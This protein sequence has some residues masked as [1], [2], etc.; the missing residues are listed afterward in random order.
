MISY[1]EPIR[2]THTIGTK[3]DYEF[4][5]VASLI[6]KQ[7]STDEN[8][9]PKYKDG[10]AATSKF[11]TGVLME[12]D[13]SKGELPLLTLRPTA[14]KNA[15]KE[16]LWIWQDQSNDLNLLRDKYNITWWDNWSLPDRTIG[17]C[18]GET[19]RRHN[20][21]NNLLNSFRENPFGRRHIASLWQMDDLEQEHALDPCAFMFMCSARRGDPKNILDMTLIQRSN[22]FA[23]A[24]A[25]N[26]FQY[27]ALQYIIAADRDMT[28]GV[29]KHFIQ[30]CHIYERHIPDVEI[31]LQRE[32]ITFPVGKEPRLVLNP[33]KHNFYT[34]AIDDF[35][36][37]NYDTKEI[38]KVNPQIVSFRDDIAI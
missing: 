25:I 2:P 30:N 21:M 24:N 7:G 5:R 27:I 17:T 8:P 33:N 26:S 28:P 4:F 13:L 14:W 3:G 35:S 32:P 10:S 34:F 6:L 29:F 11:V 1:T 15:I 19:V 18:Y 31:M 38:A 23:V 12:Y 36:V 16:M 20:I 22:D 9:R 37:E